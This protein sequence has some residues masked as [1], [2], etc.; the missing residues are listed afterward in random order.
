M[1]NI[2][3]PRTNVHA[4]GMS[5][6]ACWERSIASVVWLLK[7]AYFALNQEDLPALDLQV[8]RRQR[9]QPSL[10]PTVFLPAG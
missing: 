3:A 1:Y 2:A 6:N 10:N 7:Y 4:G 5:A 9:A 8:I